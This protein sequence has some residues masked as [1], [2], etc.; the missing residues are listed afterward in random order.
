[1]EAVNIGIV[2]FTDSGP[3]L[4]FSKSM[5]KINALD[6]DVSWDTVHQ[7]IKEIEQA[8]RLLLEAK[9]SKKDLIAFLSR[10]KWEGV[11]Y[12]HHHSIPVEGRT[13][14]EIIFHLMQKF[15]FPLSRKNKG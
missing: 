9:V 10:E 1:M 5:K 8:T 4:E 2:I 15:V 13:V 12:S 14:Q 11:Q 3:V 6:L 7:Q